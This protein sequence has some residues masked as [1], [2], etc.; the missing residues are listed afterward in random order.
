MWIKDPSTGQ[1]SVSLTLSIISFIGCIIASGLEMAE[2]VHNTGL[3]LEVFY[4]NIALYF[5]RKFTSSKGLVLDSKSDSP[6]ES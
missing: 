1:P 4:G 6:S 2:L 5:G 3:I